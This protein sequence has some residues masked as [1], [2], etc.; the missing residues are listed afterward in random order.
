MTVQELFVALGYEV[1][2]KSRKKALDDGKA[3]KDTLKKM[4]GMVGITVSVAGVVKFG[5]DCI[6][7]ASDVEQM[8]Q[9]FDVVFDSLSGQAAEWAENL[10]DSIGRSKNAIK[11]YLADAQNLFVG[12]GM[13][14]DAAMRLSEQLTESAI[15]IASFANLEEDA[16]VN[17]MTKA[18]LGQSEAAKALGAVLNENTIAM[19]MENLGLKGKFDALDEVSKMQVRY[20]AIMMQ[21]QDSIGD[22][23]RSMGS[24]ESNTRAFN[25]QIKDI[26]ETAG[27]FLLPF[28]NKGLELLSRLTGRI[29]EAADRLGGVN[30]EGTAANRIWVRFNEYGE[31]TA[32]YISR[33]IDGGKRVMDMLGGGQNA[34]KL[35]GALLASVMAYKAGGKALELAENLGSVSKALGKINIRAMLVVGAIAL[36]FLLAQDFIG[37]LQG[38]DS[39]FGALLENAGI[40]A[41]KV[42]EKFLSF[43][44]DLK[45]IFTYIRQYAGEMFAPLHEFWTL[46]GPAIIQETQ[47]FFSWIVR[48]F[49]YLLGMIGPF[50]GTVINLVKAFWALMNGDTEGAVEALKAA[51][52]NFRE[53]LGMIWQSI[54]DTLDMLF[55]GLP[56]KALEWGSDMLKG[57]IDGISGKIGALKEKI[58]SIGESIRE[59]LHFSKP[60]KGPLA[61]ADTWTPDMMDLFV[62][63]IQGRK[64][65]LKSTVTGVASLIRSTVAG[66]NG[67]GILALSGAG[68]ASP[69]TAWGAA[70]N[71]STRNIVQNL[72]FH[73]TFNGGDREVQR[74]SAEQMDKNAHD[75]SSYLA[76]A[77][78]LGR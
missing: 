46:Y 42:R 18:V 38:K 61:D 50:L 71:Y 25:A 37:F 29:R 19:S 69:G 9:K 75:A 14:R 55:G 53:F 31:K 11:T 24:F 49:G 7:A 60:D 8:E 44:A 52:E 27:K 76:D 68:E 43:G 1:D 57:F 58:N 74:Q 62:K 35:L 64:T 4:L 15:D 21:S 63:G 77:L 16:A 66:E 54:I 10:A 72:S 22:A 12:F 41:D 32:H 3:L 20:N 45:Q 36:L 78:K 33:F 26:K 73:T 40:D 6:Q 23:A 47:A 2:E 34:L 51:W 56:S 30:E 59:R 5:K 67:T 13:E 39:L 70:G 17:N 65:E 48:Q 28:M